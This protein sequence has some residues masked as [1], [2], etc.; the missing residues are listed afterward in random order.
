MDSAGAI[1][2]PGSQAGMDVR[3]LTRGYRSLMSVAAPSRGIWTDR[4]A[5]LLLSRAARIGGLNVPALLPGPIWSTCALGVPMLSW[6]EL[7][8]EGNIDSQ[9]ARAVQASTVRPSESRSGDTQTLHA[10]M[11]RVVAACAGPVRDAIPHCPPE[12]A[13]TD[14]REC[15]LIFDQHVRSRAEAASLGRMVESA[16]SSHPDAVIWLWPTA[17]RKPGYLAARHKLPR[18]IGRIRG[19]Y[20]LFAA[21]PHVD[22]VYTFD[23]PEGFQAMLAGIPVHVFGTPYYAGWGLTQDAVS[24]PERTARPSLGSLFEVVY[25]RLARYLDPISHTAGSLSQ[26]LD[27]IELQ[28]AIRSRYADCG[29]VAG[30]RFQLWKR[31]FAAPFLTAGGGRLGWLASEAQVRRGTRV[32]L[33]GSRSADGLP[34]G[35]LTLRMEDGF[36]H[37]DGLGSDMSPPGSQVI[38]REGLYFD[39]RTPNELTRILNHATFDAD[40]LARAARLR[41]EICALRVTKYNLGRRIPEWRPPEGK[42][43]V[44]V[45]GQVADDASIRFGTGAI[46]TAEALLEAVRERNPAAFIVYKPHPDVLSGNRVGHVHASELADVVDAQA[47]LLSLIDLAHEV[48]VLSSLAGFDALLRGKLVFTYG[49]PFY[50]GWGLTVDALPQSWRERQLSLDMLVAGTLLRYPIYWD[51]RTRMFTTPEAVVRR[52]GK[53]AGRPLKPI[54][55]DRARFLRKLWRWCRN[56]ARYGAWCWQQRFYPD[57]APR[58]A[59]TD[60]TT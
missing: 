24:M 14:S 26:L 55:Q 28:R 58:T 52:L 31:P 18:S 43:V 35:T 50:A 39:A 48:H 46:S 60:R 2:K 45:A 56:V 25:L 59:P 16:V 38:D 33:W 5:G 17:G 29:D 13:T 36:L 10:L 49:L 3:S 30:M 44:L 27:S 8:G 54:D 47:D 42:T 15:V 51:W 19:G 4:A 34:A 22:H 7:T 37:S 21:L 41:G 6:F 57:P 12:L 23:A 9:L 20:S 32:A 53:T 11:S 40:E 1:G